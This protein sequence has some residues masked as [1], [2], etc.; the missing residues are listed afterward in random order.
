MNRSK[1]MDAK[2]LA[3]KTIQYWPFIILLI[4]ILFSASIRFRLKDT[5]LERDEGEYAYAGQLI[6]HGVPPYEQAYNMKMPGIYAVYAMILVVFGQTQGGIHLGLLVVNSATIIL[7]FLLVRKLFDP[8]SAVVSSAAFAV[9]SLSQSV[10][11]IFANAEHFVI[12]FALAGILLLLKAVEKR[13][14]LSL[15]ASGI[16]LGTAFLIKQHG[17]AF[18][19]FAGLYLI[20]CEIHSKPF[21]MKS[22]LARCVLFA[23]AA[24][25]PITITCLILWFCGVF[26]KF[27]FWTVDYAKI[28]VTLPLSSDI[29]EILKLQINHIVI[30]SA[31]LLWSMAVI[32]LAGLWFNKKKRQHWLFVIGFVIFSALAVCPGFYF[33]PHYFVLLL[34]A[35]ALLVGLG[36]TSIEYLIQRNSSNLSAKVI[37]AILSLLVVCH[38]VWK[39]RTF[40]FIANPTIV[41][42]A[43]YP[44]HY[45]PEMLEV[46][47]FIKAN[48][49]EDDRIAVLGSEPE[50]CF[51]SHRRSA[52]GYIYTYA[53]MEPHRYALFMQ[54]EMIGEIESVK[55]KFLVLVNVL[56]S[57]L[58]RPDSE[59][60]I[61]EW[62]NQY[63]KNYQPIGIVDLI[64][65]G[66]AVY[67]WNDDV[68]GYS[69]R[70]ESYILILK[71]KP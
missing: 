48:S 71:L 20:I 2:K 54:K 45:F 69:P 28:Y 33:R 55:P 46:A 43:T 53:L 42:V 17:A 68:A 35:A 64:E 32:G 29:I 62:F 25:L 34:P 66:E 7:L 56:S 51:Y 37:V 6:L 52:T 16:L 12:F 1:K 61:F 4:I 15:L 39:Q 11:G 59:K 41:S 3:Q 50:I 24:I 49:A 10:Q 40:F 67:R 27:W 70:S 63:Q 9:F 47:R 22:M 8:F 23:I 21:T 19:V 60:M 26:D 31:L 14:I 38:A 57:W 13:N 36:A 44:Y 30:S 5:P 18:I 58:L 65:P